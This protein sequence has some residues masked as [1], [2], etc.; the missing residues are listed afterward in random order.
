MNAIWILL[1]IVAV[2]VVWKYLKGTMKSRA[3]PAGK[4]DGP[5]TYEIA[6][7]G[8]SHYQD[9]LESICG[10]RT[11]ASAE[12][13]CQAALILEDWNAQDNR[14]VRVDIQRQTVG[15]LSRE[16][17]RVY[18]RRLAEAGHPDLVGICNAVIR[19][20]WERGRG[21]RGHFGVWLD[22]PTS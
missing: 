15:Y 13:Y 17:A 10:E 7:V 2:I 5:G 3:A 19:G 21:D 16:L 1:I 20:G 6:V 11:E 12:K 14:A 22:L 9:A 4:L 18:R 8:E